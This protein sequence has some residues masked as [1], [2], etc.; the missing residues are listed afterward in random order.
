[1][2]TFSNYEILNMI[3][4]KQDDDVTLIYQTRLDKHH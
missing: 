4:I 2:L 1:M 3:S